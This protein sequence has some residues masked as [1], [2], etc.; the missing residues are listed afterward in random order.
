MK[1]KFIITMNRMERDWSWFSEYFRAAFIKLDAF[2]IVF[3]QSGCRSFVLIHH[4]SIYSLLLLF[5]GSE[6]VFES[7][8]ICVNI[9]LMYK[10]LHP[11]SC[12]GSIRKG[13]RNAGLSSRIKSYLIVSIKLDYWYFCSINST[14]GLISNTLSVFL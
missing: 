12:F 14:C 10:R 8:Y 7:R 9:H 5:R 1:K 6:S 3:H 2:R 4:A 11:H 13:K